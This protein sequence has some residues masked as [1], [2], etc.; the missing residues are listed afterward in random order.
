MFK[1]FTT[2]LHQ[3]FFITHSTEKNIYEILR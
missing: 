1:T 3:L 2:L